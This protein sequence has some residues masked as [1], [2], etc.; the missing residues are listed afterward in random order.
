MK[1]LLKRLL[2]KPQKQ[3]RQSRPQKPQINHRKKERAKIVK[4]SKEL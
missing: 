1:K 3:V 4:Y 2:N